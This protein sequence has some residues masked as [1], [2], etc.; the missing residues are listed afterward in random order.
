MKSADYLLGLLAIISGLA[1]ADMVASLHHLLISR[2]AVRWDWLAPCAAAYVFLMIVFSWGISYQAFNRF[3]INPP[4]WVF[5]TTLCQLVAIYLAARTALPDDL[6]GDGCDL[7]AYY[8]RVSRYIWTSI[9]AC[10]LL[11]LGLSAFY[12][13]NHGVIIER[14]SVIVTLPPTIALILFRQRAVHRLLVP[15]LLAFFVAYAFPRP[16]LG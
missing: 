8:D 2:R 11:L 13:V 1:I 15:A 14:W 7:A 6:S 4:V 5:I 10:Y 3:I 9:A 16:L 12:R